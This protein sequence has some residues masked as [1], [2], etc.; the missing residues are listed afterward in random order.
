[1]PV[2]QFAISLYGAI[3]VYQKIYAVRREAVR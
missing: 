2:I 3:V 1:M